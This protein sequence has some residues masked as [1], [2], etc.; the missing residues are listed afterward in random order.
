MAALPVCGPVDACAADW[1]SAT[2]KFP[3][4]CRPL[5][6][7]GDYRARCGDYNARVTLG[8]DYESA[9]YYDADTGELLGASGWLGSPLNRYCH[10]FSNRFV[11]P[12]TL[13][14]SVCVPLS[15]MACSDLTP[16]R[17]L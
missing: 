17:D 4:D 10:S 1:T 16:V 8:A 7:G 9:D 12:A 6:G 3:R 15:G 11:P 2:S 14:V 13:D 5:P